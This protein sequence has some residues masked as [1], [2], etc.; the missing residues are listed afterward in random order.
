MVQKATHPLLDSPKTSH[1]F[2]GRAGGVSQGIYEGLN[3]GEGSNDDPA[4]V[5]QNRKLV[6]DDLKSTHLLSVHQSHSAHVVFV[7]HPFEQKPKVDAMVTKTP[8]LALGVLAADCMTVLFSAPGAGIVGAAHAGWKG[9]LSGILENT[10][11]EI[12]KQGGDPDDIRAVFGPCLRPPFFEV[13]LELVEEFISKYPESADCFFQDIPTKRQLDLVKFGHKR[14]V[15][16]GLSP[17]HI[18][19]T[20]GNTLAEPDK[21]FSYRASRM[22]EQPDYGRHVSAICLRG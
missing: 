3:C 8:G 19:D 11:A 5:A 15:E 2:Y 4:L 9:A 6:A 7:D 21:Y 13:G 20:G 1:G 16:A 22:R 12:I 14:L 10:V 18:G 17:E